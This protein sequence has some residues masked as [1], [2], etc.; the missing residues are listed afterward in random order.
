MPFR[1]KAVLKREALVRFFAAILAVISIITLICAFFWPFISSDFELGKIQKLQKFDV[2]TSQL[3]VEAFTENKEPTFEAINT[4]FFLDRCQKY[5][6]PLITNSKN[7]IINSLLGPVKSDL[8]WAECDSLNNAEFK[9]LF[10]SS[11]IPDSDFQRCTKIWITEQVGIPS[12]EQFLLEMLASLLIAEEYFILTL[13]IAFTLLFPVFKSCGLF[14][15]SIKIGCE[16]NYQRSLNILSY[17]GKWSM[18]DVFVVALMISIFKAESLNFKFEVEPGLVMF[19]ISGLTT[20][21]GVLLLNV[22]TSENRLQ[23]SD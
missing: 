9:A 6:Q 13:L 21:L 23:N 10:K 4:G 7:A 19:A 16:S 5:I 11:S 1:V 2:V 14:W 22:L 20:S 15:L 17:M 18:T 8:T 3:C 12:G